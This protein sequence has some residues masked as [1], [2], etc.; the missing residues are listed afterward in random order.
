[1]TRRQ[2][3][4]GEQESNTA[5]RYVDVES[6]TPC[7]RLVFRECAAKRSPNGEASRPHRT[8]QSDDFRS[9]SGGRMSGDICE[10]SERG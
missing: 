10:V 2:A 1:M 6:P 3:A 7:K 9:V 5:E 8:D 4:N